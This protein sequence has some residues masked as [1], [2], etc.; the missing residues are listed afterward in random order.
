[1]SKKTVQFQSQKGERKFDA[2]VGAAMDRL[3]EKSHPDQILSAKHE[4]RGGR[5]AQEVLNQD[6]EAGQMDEQFPV[7]LSR[8]DDGDEL[9]SLKLAS[10]V[11]QPDGRAVPG[12]TPFGML[13]AKDEDFK[14]LAK[15]R[16]QAEVANLHT[17]FAKHYDH[18]SPEKKKLARELFPEFY[19][20]RAKLLAANVKLAHRIARVKLFGP[21]NIRDMLLLYAI[22]MGYI[23]A[24]PLENLLHPE[25]GELN[26]TETRRQAQF[27]RGLLNP[28]ARNRNDQLQPPGDGFGYY[29]PDGYEYGTM[30]R[31]SYNQQV[32]SG[33]QPS[34]FAGVGEIGNAQR[35]RT[36]FRSQLDELMTSLGVNTVGATNRQNRYDAV[37]AQFARDQQAAQQPAQQGV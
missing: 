22:E 30:F 10:N 19:A 12:M 35:P 37:S 28:R 20:Q 2:N 24:D 11:I 21:Q 31:R 5:T 17:W 32:L 23:A 3:D 27:Q 8:K 14:W 34:P 36:G 6:V 13:Q 4:E 33:R 26:A 1:M 15:K 9:R 16:A 25:R 7:D 18:A 29:A